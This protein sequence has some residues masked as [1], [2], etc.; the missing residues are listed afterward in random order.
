VLARCRPGGCPPLTPSAC[1]N[2]VLVQHA[3]G[4]CAIHAHLATVAVAARQRVL[5]GTPLGTVGA[6]GLATVPH[7]HYDRITCDTRISLAW[8]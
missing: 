5:R 4:T 8:A 7:L 1:G 6:S 3:D 2:E